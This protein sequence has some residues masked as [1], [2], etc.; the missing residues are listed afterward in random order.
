MPAGGEL[1]LDTCVYIDG[2]QGRSSDAVKVLLRTRSLNHSTIALA[3]MTHLFG[4]LDPA[5]PRTEPALARITDVIRAIPAHRLHEAD[6]ETMATAG[7]L[8]GTLCRLCGY[9]A[10]KRQRALHDCIMYLQARKLGL[11]VLTGNV[12]DFDLIQQLVP[13][14]R[15]LIYR[16][17]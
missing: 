13:D 10:D 11:T 16:R 15:L 9:G 8:A 4:R 2:L 6:A 12:G 3:E 17:Q 5:D 14:G 1:L 7:I